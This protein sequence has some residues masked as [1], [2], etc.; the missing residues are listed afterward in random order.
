MKSWI[1]DGACLL[2]FERHFQRQ[3]VL[4]PAFLDR[5][6]QIRVQQIEIEPRAA[7]VVEGLIGE[8]HRF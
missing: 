8:I 3:T 6:R 4:P 7:R 1:T 5:Q 2:K